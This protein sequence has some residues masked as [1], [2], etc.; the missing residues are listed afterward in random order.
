MKIS[1]LAEAERHFP[2]A[3]QG[4]LGRVLKHSTAQ[5]NGVLPR[6]RRSTATSSFT[7]PAMT[8]RTSSRFRAAKPT[9]DGS[10]RT[11]TCGWISNRASGEP[12]RPGRPHPS[13][14][15]HI[16]TLRG[17]DFKPQRSGIVACGWCKRAEVDLSPSSGTKAG[18]VHDNCQRHDRSR[19]FVGNGLLAGG[20][21]AKGEIATVNQTFQPS[22]RCSA[23]NSL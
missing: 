11:W 7:C 21:A 18:T 20:G 19:Y 14:R 22:G 4:A 9:P 2:V 1:W 8:A 10:T 6:R 12:G 5:R 16:S 23:P 17:R 13:A 15:A 3:R